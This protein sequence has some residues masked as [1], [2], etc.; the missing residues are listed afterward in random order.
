MSDYL[1]LFRKTE[2]LLEGHFELSS[3]KHSDQYFQCALVLQHPEHCETL[4][5]G[6]AD[7]CR[8]T[9]IDCVIGPALGGTDVV[10]LDRST[11]QLIDEI[12][13]ETGQDDSKTV[14]EPLQAAAPTRQWNQTGC[15][16]GR[17]PAA[18]TFRCHFDRWTS[19]Q[20]RAWVRR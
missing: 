3:G 12:N 9:K 8:D 20:I 1:D 17:S 19:A 7:L 6:L 13:K 5:K 4:A 10:E 14:A 2:A 16:L 11:E 18:P 15:Q